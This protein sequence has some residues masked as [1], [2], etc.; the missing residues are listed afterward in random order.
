M[1]LENIGEESSAPNVTIWDTSK[2]TADIT[3]VHTVPNTNPITTK[4][5]V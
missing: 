4:I 5:S 1:Q 2:E 3:N